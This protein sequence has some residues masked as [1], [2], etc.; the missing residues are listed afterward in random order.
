MVKQSQGFTED[1]EVSKIIFFLS[2]A[3]EARK[4]NESD[5]FL[6]SCSRK[7]KKNENKN[8]YPGGGFQMFAG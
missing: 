5:K 3:K 2:K 4:R 8:N 7:K 6:P 1:T